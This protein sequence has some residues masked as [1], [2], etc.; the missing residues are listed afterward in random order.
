MLVGDVG[1]W[2]GFFGQQANDGVGTKQQGWIG[3]RQPDELAD[4]FIAR[5]GALPPPGGDR[6]RSRFPLVAR[7]FLVVAEN[8]RTDQG[9]VRVAFGDDP[10]G[11]GWPVMAVGVVSSHGLEPLAQGDA[12]QARRAGVGGVGAH[13]PPAVPLPDLRLARP[14]AAGV[15]HHQRRIDEEQRRLVRCGPASLIQVPVASIPRVQPASGTRPRS[16]STTTPLSFATRALSPSRHARSTPRN[17]SIAIPLPHS[18]IGLSQ[19]PRT[20][21]HIVDAP[22]FYRAAAGNAARAAW[23]MF[24]ISAP[25]R[26]CAFRER[27]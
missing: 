26:L 23:R 6:E 27:K 16:S 15:G 25:V 11:G 9:G 17:R 20:T 10:V 22:G 13:L 21:G 24:S 14:L 1:L 2:G 4:Q 19:T 18:K 12:S 7:A 3:G 8:R 5:R